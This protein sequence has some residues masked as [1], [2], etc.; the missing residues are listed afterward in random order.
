MT[1]QSVQLRA[2]AQCLDQQS[3]R[4]RGSAA[5]VVEVIAWVRRAPVLEHSLQTP[6]G[7]MLLHQVLRDIGQPQ[8]VQ[9]SIEHLGR[10]IEDQLPVHADVDFSPAFFELP[11]VQTATGGEAEIDAVVL[12]QLLRLL[13]YRLL[14]KI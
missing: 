13:G 7:Q 4:R 10:A 2:V 9:G 3:K 11:S 5:G 8:A 1:Y 6:F 12:R 14:R